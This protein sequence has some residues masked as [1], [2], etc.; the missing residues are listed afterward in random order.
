LADLKEKVNFQENF[1]AKLVCKKSYE[2]NGKP[3]LPP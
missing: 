1:L 2:L 3:E